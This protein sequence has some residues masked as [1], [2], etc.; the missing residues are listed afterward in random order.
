MSKILRDKEIGTVQAHALLFLTQEQKRPLSEWRRRVDM[1]SVN[2]ITNSLCKLREPR[3]SVWN[4][5]PFR[6]VNDPSSV[7][8]RTKERTWWKL[9]VDLG[10]STGGTT[11]AFTSETYET[12]P[13]DWDQ[14]IV[15]SSIPHSTSTLPACVLALKKNE[16]SIG[17]FGDKKSFASF[18]HGVND[19][20]FLESYLL[21]SNTIIVR[22]G[23]RNTLTGGL[24]DED[25]FSFKRDG[26]RSISPHALDGTE[27]TLVEEI[28]KVDTD[29]P[30]TF[31]DTSSC[32][33]GFNDLAGAQ[34]KVIYKQSEMVLSTNLV[35]AVLGH[36]S[37]FF[38]IF[39]DGTVQ[40]YQNGSLIASLKI[41]LP[42]THGIL[43]F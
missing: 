29:Y 42:I 22:V 17:C 19:A 43:K 16:I 11:S 15:F 20:D 2:L 41:N 28:S 38:A 26:E 36:P 21:P 31:T 14:A 4:W 9:S 6:N 30:W 34:S 10:R 24:T 1:S 37:A 39:Y 35:V 25:F 27:T 8:V 32:L 13:D 18:A 33:T 12:E 3:D 40:R 5:K 7:L 23:K